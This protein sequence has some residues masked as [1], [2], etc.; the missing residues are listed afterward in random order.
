M[1]RRIFVIHGYTADSRQHW[2]PWLTAELSSDTTDVTVLDLPDSSAPEPNRWVG[3]VR[4][5]V[6]HVDE[7]TV[8]VGHSLGCITILRYLESLDSE[9]SLGSLVL[10]SG[11]AEP[12]PNLPALD[13]FVVDPIDLSALRGRIGSIAVVASDNDSIVSPAATQRLAAGLHS[14][15]S[16]IEGAGHFLGR[17]GH[18]TL[19]AILP[20]IPA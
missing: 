9:W 20:L 6:G 7:E 13:G 18:L 19:P 2:F 5:A 8:L 10:V 16:T 4:D 15:V 3:A 11:F 17:E 1:S 12:L 14:T